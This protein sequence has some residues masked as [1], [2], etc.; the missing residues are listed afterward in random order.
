MKDIFSL[1]TGI[2]FSQKGE[3][4]PQL[5]DLERLTFILFV[6]KSYI[7]AEIPVSGSSNVPPLSLLKVVAS[8]ISD[9]PD[10]CLTTCPA[11]LLTAGRLRGSLAPPESTP[12]PSGPILGLLRWVVLMPLAGNYSAIDGHTQR[13]LRLLYSQLHLAIIQAFLSAGKNEENPQDEMELE[14]GEVMDESDSSHLIKGADLRELTQDMI[15]LIEKFKTAEFKHSF[16][17]QQV[18]LS[19][20]RYGQTLQVAIATA[21]VS[22]SKGELN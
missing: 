14:P 16:V 2:Y 1:G 3:P 10:L 15:N 9:N 11:A 19:L 8:W 17:D 5:Q 12:L 20:D 18:Q 6:T 21:C 13:E 22:A 7:S 4:V